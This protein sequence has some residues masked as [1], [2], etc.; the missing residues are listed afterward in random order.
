[1]NIKTIGI[2]AAIIVFVILVMR[3]CF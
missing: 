2:I 3:A 1:M